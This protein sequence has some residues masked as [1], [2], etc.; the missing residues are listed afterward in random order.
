M[1]IKRN[2]EPCEVIEP[3]LGVTPGQTEEAGRQEGRI[4]V[5]R[6]GA[7]QAGWKGNCWGSEDESLVFDLAVK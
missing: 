6:Q 3:E 4:G 1:R 5:E 7:P 2:L